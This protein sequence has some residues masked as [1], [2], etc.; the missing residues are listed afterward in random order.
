MPDPTGGTPAGD[1]MAALYGAG[2]AGSDPFSASAGM[3]AGGGYD[4]FA[5]FGM[6]A[7]PSMTGGGMASWDQGQTAAMPGAVYPDPAQAALSVIPNPD[8]STD[9]L[10]M[11]IPSGDELYNLLMGKIEPELTTDQLPL[12]DE[13]YHGETPDESK[14]RA[15]RY[16][17]AFAE[18][19]KQLQDYMEGLKQKLRAHQR[20]AMSSAELGA[21]AEEEDALT[22]IE[23]SIQ[24]S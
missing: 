16:E 5:S 21:K 23:A 24:K 13:R 6:G 9:Y 2:G 4:P 20:I 12:L 18:Y 19:D 17:K 3:P 22:A 14:A 7:S 1:P 10:G 11:R 8:G 15:K